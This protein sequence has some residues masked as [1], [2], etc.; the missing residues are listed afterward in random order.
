M[1]HIKHTCRDYNRSGNILLNRLIGADVRLMPP[2]TDVE[3][4]CDELAATL[5]ATGQS[6]YVVPDGGS[7]ATGCLGYVA[8]ASE[9]AAQ[10]CSLDIGLDNI[11]LTTGSCGTHAG[12]L[13]DPVYTGKAMSGMID[14]IRQ[15]HFDAK[16]T[17]VFLHTG[18]TPGL[19]GYVDTFSKHHKGVSI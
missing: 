5:R 3:S 10:A 9:L 19:Y 14:P 1:H 4:A 2:G 16:Q 7:N 13:L 11:V 15:G 6:P 17:L 8:A 12:L 18:G